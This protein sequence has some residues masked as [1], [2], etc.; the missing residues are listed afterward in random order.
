MA[1]QRLLERDAVFGAVGP[2]LRSA[3]DG[4]VASVFLVGEAGLGK[5]AVLAAAVGRAAGFQVLESRGEAAGVSLPFG[6]LAQVAGSAQA[7]EVLAPVS[8]LPAAERAAAAWSRLRRWASADRPA[9][10]LLALDDLHWA[11]PDSVTLL[12]L[13]LQ[14]VR[15]APMAVIATLRPWPSAA[16]ELVAEVAADGLGTAVRLRPLS[17]AAS[18]ELLG[19]LTGAP[20]GAALLGRLEELCAGNPLLLHQLARDLQ[21]R[22]GPVTSIDV[23]DPGRLL[24]SRFTGLGPAGLDFARAAAVCGVQFH[25]QVAAAL[26]G[27]SSVQAR[28]ALTGL[29]QAGLVRSADG[30]LAGFTHALLQQALYEDLPDPV[31]V[32]LHAATFGLLWQQGLPAAEAARHA[33]AGHLRGDTSAV[34]CLEQAGLD[35]MSRGA[36]DAATRWLTAA[37][38]LAGQR[39]EPRLRLRLA[40]ALHASGAPARAADVCKALLRG[41]EDHPPPW[42]AEA[43]RLFG[44]LLYEMGEIAQAGE[45]LEHAARLAAGTN[46]R[47]AVEA[48]LEASL[49][50]FTLTGPRRALRFA[51]AASH[52][53]TEDSDPELAAW[54]AAARGNARIM[55]A[56]PG[57][58]AEVERAVAALPGGAGL[59]GLHGSVVFGPRFAQLVA[60]KF[61]ER[62]TEATEV[63]DLAMAEAQHAEV[64]FAFSIIYG[65]THAET[66]I[67]LGRLAEAQ[68][69]FEQAMEDAPWLPVRW[70]WAAMGLAI[71]SF[72]L[73]RPGRAA[74]YCERIESA[75]PHRENTLPFL[76]ILVW[77][78]RA[79]LTLQAGDTETACSLMQRAEQAA[80]QTGLYEPCAVPWAETAITAYLRA[81]RLADT[82]RIIDQLLTMSSQLPCQLTR[83]IAARGQAL[84]ADQAGDRDTAHR[85]FTN[86]L[87]AH[88]PLPMPLAEAE[89][90]LVYGGFL[91]RT[92]A[93]TAARHMLHQAVH[94]AGSCGA[95][96]LERLAT[97]ELH[98]AGGRRRTGQPDAETLTPVQHRIAT[99]VANGLTNSEIGRQ[100]LISHRTVEHHLTNIYATLGLSSRRQL[101]D[102]V[103]ARTPGTDPT[104]STSGQDHH[105]A[106]VRLA[107]GRSTSAQR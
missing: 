8:D 9:P 95:A 21:D 80:Q 25:P 29:C 22:A 86:A 70:P 68:Q 24:L 98:A 19:R 72:E 28:D 65:V 30:G 92:G 36:L 33:I 102:F 106:Q 11:D 67:R 43:Y 4:R 107:R 47:L 78:I 85:H 3:R 57:G 71:V 91:R 53:L 101:R 84:L 76:W 7:G 55:M 69:L 10:L 49:Q 93:A 23:A 99:L 105:S 73:D 100:L 32:Q 13:L 48:L 56:D 104:P 83:A 64:P 75:V 18:A 82:Q 35:A 44:R 16:A 45:S 46:R 1:D 12:R 27:L 74:S 63:F 14:Q 66:L 60:A 54:V 58:A 90:R 87:T 40:D 59:R 39:A 5:T 81:G 31:R 50:E 17:P 96:R 97:E 51:E 61:Q 2:A 6:F 42:V 15:A 94:I 77:T 62:F 20:L 79:N 26:A 38:E 52:L 88:E 41:H 103:K 37:V 34:T 89:T